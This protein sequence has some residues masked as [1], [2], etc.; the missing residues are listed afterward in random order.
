M[1]W[2]AL[3]ESHNSQMIVI[4]DYYF[5]KSLTL[6][7]E[8]K[9]MMYLLSA[10]SVTQLNNR[11]SNPQRKYFMSDQFENVF[12]GVWQ[13]LRKKRPEIFP[14]NQ[15]LKILRCSKHRLSIL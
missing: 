13:T 8:N 1:D 3:N 9:L 5:N 11:R 14:E 6:D 12:E 2:K 7:I 4:G 15:K 10:E